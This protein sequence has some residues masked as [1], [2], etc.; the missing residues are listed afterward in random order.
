MRRSPV[1]AALCEAVCI[2]IAAVAPRRTRH[3]FP[4]WVGVAAALLAPR[5][6]RPP[7]GSPTPM[8]PSLGGRD[9]HGCFH[10][11]AA[12]RPPVPPRGGRTGGRRP[13]PLPPLRGAVWEPR[14]SPLRAEWPRFAPRRRAAREAGVRGRRP[15]RPMAR[16]R[17]SARLRRASR[18]RTLRTLASSGTG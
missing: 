14:S 7:L 11:I 5:R 9:A 16:I 6:W 4:L 1:I 18:P 10:A 12:P 15:W 2:A 3:V 13:P 8:G 17:P